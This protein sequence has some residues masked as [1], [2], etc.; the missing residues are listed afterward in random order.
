MTFLVDSPVCFREPF[1]KLEDLHA[2]TCNVNFEGVA[3]R[4]GWPLLHEVMQKNQD[5]QDHQ[6]LR[7]VLSGLPI[8][9]LVQLLNLIPFGPALYYYKPVVFDWGR[10]LVLLYEGYGPAFGLGADLVDHP[11]KLL[12]YAT[13]Y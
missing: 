3:Y 5:L 9:H 13:A 8:D 6:T 1:P 7:H 4:L 10:L 2:D 11:P 12:G